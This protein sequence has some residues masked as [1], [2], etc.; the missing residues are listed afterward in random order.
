MNNTIHPK[1]TV[2]SVF[3]FG[4][5]SISYER[6]RR[7]TAAKIH[8]FSVRIFLKSY[9]NVRIQRYKLHKRFPRFP[10]YQNGSCASIS[11]IRGKNG[12]F[13]N[14]SRMLGPQKGPSSNISRFQGPQNGSFSNS[15]KIPGCQFQFQK[16]RCFQA[17]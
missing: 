15:L 10:A 17:T 12:S 16:I 2:S 14:I 13:S 1:S 6:S 7:E 4:P 9:H 11:G 3:V 8:M 5:E